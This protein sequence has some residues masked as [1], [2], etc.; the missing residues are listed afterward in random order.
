[1]SFGLERGHVPAR[2]GDEKPPLLAAELGGA[3]V[4]H[5]EHGV[6]GVKQGHLDW[7][8]G[9]RPLRR[10][11]PVGLSF[12]DRTKPLPLTTTALMPV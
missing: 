9:N 5:A 6:G 3:S 8:P 1:M 2:R 10:Y 12:H 7:A 4:P 11:Q